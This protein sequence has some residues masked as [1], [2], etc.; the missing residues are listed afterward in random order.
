VGVADLLGAASLVLS[1][2]ALD[3]LTARAGAGSRAEQAAGGAD[4]K[5]DAKDKK[6][7]GHTRAREAEQGDEN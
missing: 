6:T 7:G 5:V 4:S 1:Q 2:A 3:A